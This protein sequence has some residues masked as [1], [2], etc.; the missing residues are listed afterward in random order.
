[1]LCNT[2]VMKSLIDALL[3][4]DQV[5]WLTGRCG[6]GLQF[7]LCN[8]VRYYIWE[9]LIELSCSQV[10]RLPLTVNGY[11]HSWRESFPSR[12]SSSR[13]YWTIFFGVMTSC[14]MMYSSQETL[15]IIEVSIVFSI[16]S[17]NDYSIKL[18]SAISCLI[19][20]CRSAFWRNILAVTQSC[21]NHYFCNCPIL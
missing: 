5:C 15:A 3:T 19:L 13:R 21:T 8:W 2:G 10:H 4:S 14:V 16:Q 7:S 18:L 17:S 11:T 12:Q 1:M 6:P 20:I 9:K